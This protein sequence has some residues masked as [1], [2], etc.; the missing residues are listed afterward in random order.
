MILSQ[1]LT[2]HDLRLSDEAV[3]VAVGL[4]LG[5]AI[6][7]PHT[8]ACGAPVSS[9][10]SHGL[11]CSLGFGRQARHVTVNDL[12]FRGLN[13]AGIPAV[14]EPSGL[15]RADGKR[16][17]GQTLIPWCSGRALIWD[18]TVV[19]T[20]AASYITGTAAEAG[21]ATEIAA[22]RKHA[23]YTELQRR[24]IFIPVAVETL[25]PLNMEG[26][27]FISELGRRLTTTTGDNRETRFLFQSLSVTVQRF[28]AVAFQG[29]M[30]KL[31][32]GGE[33]WSQQH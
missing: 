8:C 31:P 18:A 26:F 5:L 3:R 33:R 22:K 13:R 27:A 28:K 15:T 9:R 12:I 11:S 1:L 25:G 6:C 21:A 32:D 24:Y 4:R 23:K 17:D 29:T 14:K 2:A 30:S 10:G 16:P 19:D 7:E 20:V